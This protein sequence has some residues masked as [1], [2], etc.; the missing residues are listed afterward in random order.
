M[1]ERELC[2]DIL[3][4]QE[5]ECEDDRIGL[6]SGIGKGEAENVQ[7]MSARGRKTAATAMQTGLF[8]IARFHSG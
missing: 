3:V 1:F 7:T 2:R 8:F 6:A 5:R 4:R